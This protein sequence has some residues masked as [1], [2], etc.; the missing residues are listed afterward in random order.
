MMNRS[1][2]FE[3]VAALAVEAIREVNETTAVTEHHSDS[4][5]TYFIVSS[6]YTQ[7][8]SDVEAIY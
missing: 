4:G 8:T 2:K 6:S 3:D 7:R 5:K 1:F